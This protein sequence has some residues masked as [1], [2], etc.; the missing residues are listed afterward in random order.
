MNG[1]TSMLRPI[2]SHYGEQ[3]TTLRNRGKHKDLNNDNR[4]IRMR[5]LVIEETSIQ[6]GYESRDIDI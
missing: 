6:I 3:R 4:V 1:H 2:F 5:V